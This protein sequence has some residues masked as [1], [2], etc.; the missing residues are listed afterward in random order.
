MPLS[1]RL[2]KRGFKSKLCKDIVTLN[3]ETLNGFETGVTIDVEQLKHSRLIKNSVERVKILGAG[4]IDH[5]LT[6]KIAMISSGARA[7]IE[8]AGGSIIE[9]V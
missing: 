2:P 6:V 3:V 1:R 7:K 4:E 8:A 5:P 9:V